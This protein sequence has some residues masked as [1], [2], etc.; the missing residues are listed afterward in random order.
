MS[1]AIVLGTVCFKFIAEN[2]MFSIKSIHDTYSYLH[3]TDH[4]SIKESIEKLD[5]KDKIM[6]IESLLNEIKKTPIKKSVKLS[7]NS[8]GHCIEDINE[9]LK[10]LKARIEYHNTKYFNSWRSF[11]SD[12]IIEKLKNKNKLLDN[13]LDLLIKLLSI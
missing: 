12:D 1:T 7:T 9:S 13:R 5:I 3:S 4:N 6:I 2:I 10:E 11:N 8:V